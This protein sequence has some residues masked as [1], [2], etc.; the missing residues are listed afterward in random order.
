MNEILDAAGDFRV[1]IENDDA[2][3]DKP[4]FDG[5]SPLL[6]F[7]YRYYPWSCEQETEITSYVV[8]SSIIEAAER[9][10]AGRER[11]MFERY[12]RIF[13]GA[14]TIVWHESRDYLYCTFDTAAWREA[15]GLTPEHLAKHP[16]I[17][18][19]DMDEFIAW[20]NG[21]VYGYAVQ[22]REVHVQGRHEAAAREE[23]GNVAYDAV[24]AR[25][26]ELAAAEDSYEWETVDSCSGFYGYTD[27]LKGE[28]LAAFKAYADTKDERR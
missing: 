1:I 26:S 11:K 18:L 27:Y 28:A 17:E 25:A 7:E 20:L 19:A 16:D 12:L 15:M 23:L 8:D 13:H 2:S 24:M 9:F 3:P 21:E 6:R 5:G 22:R 10:G 14:T 4:Y